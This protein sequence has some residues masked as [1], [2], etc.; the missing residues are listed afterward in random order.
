MWLDQSDFEDSNSVKIQ[1]NQ[2]KNILYNV[3]GLTPQTTWIMFGYKTSEDSTENPFISDYNP[4]SNN[5][6]SISHEQIKFGIK[7]NR[8]ITGN[9]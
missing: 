6:I 3:D 5:G 4:D 1:S 2:L 7:E 9:T 8:R